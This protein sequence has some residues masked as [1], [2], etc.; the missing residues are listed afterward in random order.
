MS[1]SQLKL[2]G[3][4]NRPICFS[5]CAYEQHIVQYG[6][7]HTRSQFRTKYAS[8]EKARS[9]ALLVESLAESYSHSVYTSLC[10]HLQRI[11]RSFLEHVRNTVT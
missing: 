2:R 5:L 11:K 1:I 6:I 8:D 10:F 9:G 4:N 3:I 7:G